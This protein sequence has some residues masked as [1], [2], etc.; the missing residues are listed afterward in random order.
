MPPFLFIKNI[1]FY[2]SDFVLL[3][4]IHGCI[5]SNCNA[6]NC[7]LQCPDTT[8]PTPNPSTSVCSCPATEAGGKQSITNYYYITCTWVN[9]KKK[10]HCFSNLKLWLFMQDTESNVWRLLVFFMI[11][12]KQLHIRFNLFIS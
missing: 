1:M 12:T 4:C 10:T 7:R 6:M 2:V 8:C 11:V 5:P 3:L 9:K